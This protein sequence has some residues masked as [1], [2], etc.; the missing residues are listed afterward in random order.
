MHTE[1]NL[2]STPELA[3]A[4]HEYSIAHSTPLDKRVDEHRERTLRFCEEQGLD[5]VMMISSL[6]VSGQCGGEGVGFL[7]GR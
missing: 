6:Q 5:P 4:V 1:S 3:E 2:G 7:C